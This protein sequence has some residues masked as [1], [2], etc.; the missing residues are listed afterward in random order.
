MWNCEYFFSQKCCVQVKSVLSRK[1]ISEGYTSRKCLRTTFLFKIALQYTLELWRYCNIWR[2]SLLN[3]VDSSCSYWRVYFFMW[4]LGLA[5]ELCRFYCVGQANKKKA[6]FIQCTSAVFI[7]WIGASLAL[8]TIT[9][10]ACSFPLVHKWCC[11]ALKVL[12]IS[13]EPGGVSDE[14]HEVHHLSHLPPLPLHCGVCT[15]GHA[16]LWWQVT[17]W[18]PVAAM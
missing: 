9:F 3:H 17:H 14:L 6:I 15:A 10:G 12:G 5:I 13:E 16:A 4:I 11:V 2:S 8:N 18:W 1:S 7:T